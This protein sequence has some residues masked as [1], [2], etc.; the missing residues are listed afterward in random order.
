V[1]PRAW[2]VTLRDRGPAGEVVLRPLR[3]RDARAWREARAANARWLQP[4]EATAPPGA[5]ERIPGFSDMVRQLREDARNGRGLPFAVLLDGQFVGQLSVAGIS[6]GS[7]RGCFMGYWV[8]E[9][10]AGRGVIPTAVALATDHVFEALHLHRVE[11]GIRPENIASRRV[12]EKLGFR[13]EGVR[14]KFLH[15]NGDWRDHVIYVMNNGDL[16]N[17][18]MARWRETRKVA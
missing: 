18:V 16:P 1:K 8:D 5:G 7:Y 3:L 13:L 9:R 12:A 15:I 11:L 17:G 4:W 14:E 6:Y 10:V 2:P